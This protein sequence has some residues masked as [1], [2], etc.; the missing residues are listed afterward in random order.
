MGLSK[1]EDRDLSFC[2]RAR[3]F[4]SLCLSSCLTTMNSGHKMTGTSLL[5][6]TVTCLTTKCNLYPF[7]GVQTREHRTP[8]TAVRHVS[9][10]HETEEERE[11]PTTTPYH[12][13]IRCFCELVACPIALFLLYYSTWNLDSLVSRFLSVIWFQFAPRSFPTL[14]GRP[15][16]SIARLCLFLL[17]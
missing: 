11:E 5:K 7:L 3:T 9:D 8:C 10:K 13:F 17:L 6:N 14:F 1:G 16:L 2:A 4:H 15:R 12:S